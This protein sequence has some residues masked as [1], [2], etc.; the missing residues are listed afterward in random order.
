VLKAPPSYLLNSTLTG[1]RNPDLENY[2]DTKTK[3]NLV[4]LAM[5]EY[6]IISDLS[7]SNMGNPANRIKQVKLNELVKQRLEIERML[8]REDP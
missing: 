8:I 4:S 3:N 7:K 2:I 5:A 6:N 1:L